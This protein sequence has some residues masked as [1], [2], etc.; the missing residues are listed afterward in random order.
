MACVRLLNGTDV[1]TTTEYS[2]WFD[3][4]CGHEDR[5]N[6]F[7]ALRRHLA[8]R[9]SD[10]SWGIFLCVARICIDSTPT[11]WKRMPFSTWPLAK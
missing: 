5:D 3:E 2:L 1:M 10:D 9:F 7:D 4:L 6:L 8:K 11:Q